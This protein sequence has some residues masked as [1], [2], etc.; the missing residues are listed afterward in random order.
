MPR[1]IF[2]LFSPLSPCTTSNYTS[3]TYVSSP[4]CTECRRY[5]WRERAYR[6]EPLPLLA[7]ELRLIFRGSSCGV[8]FETRFRVFPSICLF[9]P[10]RLIVHLTIL[11]RRSRFPRTATRRAYTYLET[12]REDKDDRRRRRPRRGWWRGLP[13]RASGDATSSRSSSMTATSS[14]AAARSGV[15]AA[16]V[17]QISLSRS[18]EAP[19]LHAV[20]SQNL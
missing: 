16:A 6:W 7:E 4:G 14:M 19:E 10:V 20:Y 18:R 1:V 8:P 12:K 9:R 15:S 3:S 17:F 2:V 5:R 13:T 11:S